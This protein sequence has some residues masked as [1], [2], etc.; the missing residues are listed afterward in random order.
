MVNYENADLDD[1]IRYC[2]TQIKG[3]YE[4]QKRVAIR[5]YNYVV[6]EPYV[7]QYY[8]LGWTELKELEAGYK[9]TSK[10]FMR[11]VLNTGPTWFDIIE[12][13]LAR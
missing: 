2:S 11:T 9:G 4:N 10:N 5:L 1:V 6:G 12:K 3:N 7:Y 8:A 13:E